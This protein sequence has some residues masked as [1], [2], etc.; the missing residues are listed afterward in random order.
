M[1]GEWIL[2]DYDAERI[3]DYGTKADMESRR[4]ELETN[5]QRKSYAVKKWNKEKN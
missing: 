1:P 2:W 5:L 3:V 4:A